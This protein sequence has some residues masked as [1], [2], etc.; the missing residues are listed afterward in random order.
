MYKTIATA[1]L[2]LTSLSA[3][4]AVTL[5]NGES[6][7]SAFELVSYADAAKLTDNFWEVG[8][9]V[10]DEN[11]QPFSAPTGAPSYVTLTLYENTNF[12]NEVFSGTQNTR[13]WMGDYGVYFWGNSSLF[14]D[15]NGSFTVSYSGDNNA[16]LFEVVISNFAGSLAPSNVASIYIDPTPSAVPLPAAAWL[17]ISGL[18]VLGLL[19]RKVN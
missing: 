1:F 19:R 12:T 18:G 15:L 8:L 5:G 16:N 13:D 11:N 6:Y 3:N 7:S 10:I 14:T 17:M 9:G 2:A 4:A